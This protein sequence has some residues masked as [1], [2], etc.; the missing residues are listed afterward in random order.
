MLAVVVSIGG[1]L[2]EGREGTESVREPA[3]AEGEVSRTRYLDVML[4]ACGRSEHHRVDGRDVEP[5]H[6]LHEDQPWLQTL[7]RRAARRPTPSDGEPTLPER[8]QP[9]APP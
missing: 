1:W 6:G 2:G 4:C 9:N 3:R 7:L 8:L 5:D